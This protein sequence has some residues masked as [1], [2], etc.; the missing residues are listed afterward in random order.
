MGFLLKARF[1]VWFSWW[2]LFVASA[3]RLGGVVLYSLFRVGYVAAC[4]TRRKRAAS[5]IS[6]TPFR[7][8][9]SP[10]GVLGGDYYQIPSNAPPT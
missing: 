1:G 10:I 4:A 6:G 5:L 8:G 3:S 9:A 7:R 2:I